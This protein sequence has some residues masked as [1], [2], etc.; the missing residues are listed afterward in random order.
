MGV[1]TCVLSVQDVDWRWEGWY[2]DVTVCAQLEGGN[3]YGPIAAAAGA[4]LALLDDAGATAG[5]NDAMDD[6]AR[7]LAS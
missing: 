5:T 1:P 7:R 2:E 4:L 3:W 6:A